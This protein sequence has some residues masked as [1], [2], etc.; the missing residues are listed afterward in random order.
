MVKL[1]EAIVV[2]TREGHVETLITVEAPTLTEAKAK[3]RG[4]IESDFE[5]QLIINRYMKEVSYYTG[6]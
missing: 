1:T 2:A 6:G 4:V 3:V 5:D